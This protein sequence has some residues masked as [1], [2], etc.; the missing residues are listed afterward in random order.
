M[1]QAGGKRRQNTDG[2]NEQSPDVSCMNL[3]KAVF[4]MLGAFPTINTSGEIIPVFYTVLKD[5]IVA[6]TAVDW[7]SRMTTDHATLPDQNDI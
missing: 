3:M 1:E 7:S 4:F 2:L 5:N 6:G